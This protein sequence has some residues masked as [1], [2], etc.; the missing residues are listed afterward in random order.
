MK[1]LLQQ[2]KLYKVL[3][4]VW[5]S[6]VLI[7]SSLPSIPTQKI[8]IWNEP[9]RLDYLEHFGVFL[10]WG[11]FFILWKMKPLGSFKIKNHI[12]AILGTLVFSCVDEIHQ[13]W[14]PGRT[15]NPLDLMYNSLGLIIAYA[16][17]PIYLKQVFKKELASE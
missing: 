10:I 6:I 11:G 4:W 3:F 12:W 14:I 13:I 2:K 9:F 15:F 7:L 1:K 17:V 16:L 8:N 5:G